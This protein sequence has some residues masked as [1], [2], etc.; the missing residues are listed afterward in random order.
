VEQRDGDEKGI[1]V[2]APLSEAR[3]RHRRGMANKTSL[4]LVDAKSELKKLDDT[5]TITEKLKNA[6]DTIAA[7]A[8][9]ADQ[10]HAISDKAGIAMKAVTVATLQAK[11]AALRMAEE[12]GLNQRMVAVGDAIKTR[13]ADPAAG[14]IRKHE[15]DSHSCNR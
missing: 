1:V 14:L 12:S 10:R 15:L 4:A 9:Q 3:H 2:D 11:E 5:H 7:L 8:Q 13:V 6:G